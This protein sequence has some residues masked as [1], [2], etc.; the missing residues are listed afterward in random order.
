MRSR[1]SAFVVH[2]AAYLLHTW[3][4]STRPRT[5][6]LDDHTRFT[7]LDVLGRTDGSLFD[8]EAT[9][10]FEAHYVDGGRPGVMREHSRFVREEGR[11]LYV[12]PV[13]P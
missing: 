4:P 3:H 9:V 8:H 10:L 7:R 1:Y 6:I 11:W 12:A 2:D 5:V 13:S